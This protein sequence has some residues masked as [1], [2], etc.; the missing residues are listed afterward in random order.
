M[1]NPHITLSILFYYKATLPCTYPST[2]TTTTSVRLTFIASVLICS[3]IWRAL[4]IL[5]SFVGPCVFWVF[6]MGH[7]TVGFL[8]VGC[9]CYATTAAANMTMCLNT[10][11]RSSGGWVELCGNKSF[12][13][14]SRAVVVA[15]AE[16]ARLKLHA[17]GPLR[18]ENNKILMHA[19]IDVNC[20]W[21][22]SV[23]VCERRSR[24]LL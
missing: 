21:G 9:C 6:I 7:I 23:C 5:E 8:R 20:S 10:G 19:A 16:L 24:A 13:Q 11:R 22:Q 12:R 1:C 18:R 15:A 14:F 17:K 2:F 3:L 4:W